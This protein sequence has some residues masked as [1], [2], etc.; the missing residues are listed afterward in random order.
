MSLDSYTKNNRYH[1][2]NQLVMVKRSF[3]NK[4]TDEPGTFS[5]GMDNLVLNESVSGI[6]DW[7]LRGGAGGLALGGLY[8]ALRD[9]GRDEKGKKRSRMSSILSG[10]GWGGALG[11]LGGAAAGGTLRGLQ[12]NKYREGAKVTAEHVFPEGGLSQAQFHNDEGFM[13]S[14]MDTQGYKH[15]QPEK[16]WW[17]LGLS[18][19]DREKY[20]EADRIDY[21]AMDADTEGPAGFRSSPYQQL[22]S[23]H[24]GSR[25]IPWKTALGL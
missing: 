17:H 3:E 25:A 22:T 19:K 18:L 23:S 20:P 9:P 8:G 4:Y 5:H 7:G 6:K 12:A 16:P 14:F 24:R 13:K 10:A 15:G 2:H 21:D 11:G 1:A